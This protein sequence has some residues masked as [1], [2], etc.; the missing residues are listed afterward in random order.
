M[1]LVMR[2]S[3]MIVHN[4]LHLVLDVLP[5]RTFSWQPFMMDFSDL[6]SCT[7]AGMQ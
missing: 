3:V 6:P 5:D 2:S 1:N 4:A 7:L